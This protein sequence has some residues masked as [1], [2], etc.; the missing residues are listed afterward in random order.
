MHG[1]IPNI[2]QIYLGFHTCL[3][4]TKLLMIIQKKM[5]L[6]SI[7]QME[8]A[9]LRELLRVYMLSH[10]QKNFWKMWHTLKIWSHHHL[11]WAPAILSLLLVRIKRIIPRDNLKLQRQ[12]ENFIMHL[13]VPALRISNTFSDRRLLKIVLSHQLMLTLLQEFLVQMLEL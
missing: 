10:P 7:L 1:M 5:H 2:W 8:Y 6:L 13:V 9:S 11:Q 4:N 12:Q 3:I